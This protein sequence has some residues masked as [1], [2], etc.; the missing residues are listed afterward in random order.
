MTF[1]GYIAFIPSGPY[2][3]Y[4][5]GI[6]LDILLGIILLGLL[7]PKITQI[8]KE[9][10][11]IFLISLFFFLITTLLSVLFSEDIVFSTSKW[12]SILGYILVSLLA[13]IAINDCSKIIFF[14]LFLLVIAVAIS[15]F[16]IHLALLYG[17]DNS[18]RFYLG[19]DPKAPLNY[20]SDGG[21]EDIV[22]PNM[23]A[24]GL[25]MS[26]IVYLPNFFNSHHSIKR[27]TLEILAFTLITLGTFLTASRTAILSYSLSCT[28]AL[29][30]LSTSSKR[31]ETFLIQI[32]KLFCLLLFIMIIFLGMN[33]LLPSVTGN[34]LARIGDI[35]SPDEGRKEL[36]SNALSIFFSDDKNILFGQG[37]HLLNP[38][39]E[40]LRNLTSSGVFS[41][42]AF[43][44]FL[45]TVY[46]SIVKNIKFNYWLHFSSLSLYI[47][48]LLAIQTL[49]HT[50]SLWSSLMF[51]L[52]LY[53]E[54]KHRLHKKSN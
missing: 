3:I 49:P 33:T 14:R 46:F 6:K 8:R 48:I 39:N 12:F 29:I 5:F 11:S 51:I 13:P 2:P 19:F 43:L 17:L 26:V 9:Y 15:L 32:F 28:L 24:I 41:L 31:I 53:M 7:L 38:H 47:Y 34:F 22:D 30:I 25:T 1:L 50:K 52:F 20:Q 18:Q 16:L 37:Y 4:I 44:F 23:T 40:F 54:N 27:K 36:I 35:D 10:P 42:I 21:V 45:Y